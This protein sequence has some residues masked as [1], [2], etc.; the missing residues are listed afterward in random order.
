[1]GVRET[2]LNKGPHQ[3]VLLEEVNQ[4]LKKRAIEPV[5]QE[6]ESDGFYSTF[7]L[8]PKKPKGLRPIL[9]LKPL[10]QCLVKRKFKMENLRSV[11]KA[12]K[13]GD[14]LMSLD[15]QDAYMHIPIHKSYR[16]FLRFKIGGQAFQF[17]VLP[18]G[19]SSA[20]R[21][22]TKVLAPL[23]AEARTRGLH[24]Y[25]YLDDWLLRFAIREILRGMG[26]DLVQLLDVCGFLI[27]FPKSHLDPTRGLIFIGG[28]FSTDKNLVSLP[29]EREEDLLALVGQFKLGVPKTARQFLQLLG[30]MAAA[31]EVV[32]FCRLHMRPIQ[33]YLKAFWNQGSKDLEA[34]IPVNQ[35]LLDCL[36][37]WTNVHNLRRGVPLQEE[38]PQIT[39][40]TDASSLH[41][42]GGHLESLEVQGV[43]EDAIRVQKRHINWLEME[44]VFRC[45]K[46]FQ[47]HFRGKVVLVQCDNST[48]VAYINKQGGTQS[49]S[50]CMLAWKLLK[51]AIER[52]ITLRAIHLRGKDNILADRLS[53][54]FA[55]PLEWQLNPQVVWRVCQVWGAP[56]I[57][58]FASQQNHQFPV[59]CS[60]VQDPQ[61]YHVDALT[62][63]WGNMYGYAFPPI[64][65]IPLVLDRVVQFGC[66]VI[67]IAPRWPRRSW[68][69]SLLELSVEIPLL[70]QVSPD[71][72]TQNRGRL[73]H[74]APDR[75]CLV[76]WK[77]SGDSSAVK[78]FRRT[79]L[80]PF[81]TLSGKAPLKSMSDYGRSL[82]A[83]VVQGLL[84]PMRRL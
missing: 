1:M 51:W 36:Q 83:G 22:F 29:L 42:W 32:M 24:L 23:V 18:F 73:Q 27:N 66:T 3:D 71:L 28:L 50:L 63:D 56:L 30:T 69:P 47:E 48:V 11:K 6:L 60:R 9:N 21:V 65:L 5:P 41:G 14:W 10:N 39:L 44:A 58:L 45:C 16:K 77:V 82:S 38:S 64:C 67:L 84:L 34:Q 54:T 33:M 37:W 80:I 17:L 8:V 40:T 31:I 43:W 35:H 52:D 20:P 76:A 79:S 61:A 49:P 4:L 2:P 55:D 7:F 26:Q 53:R 59:F 74:S 62:M 12:I 70:L 68:Y 13:P 15:L 78:V 19:L 25:P 75:L 72:L 57:D 81:N 46:Q